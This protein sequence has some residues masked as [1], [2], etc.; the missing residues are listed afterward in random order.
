MTRTSGATVVAGEQRDLRRHGCPGSAGVDIF[1]VARQVDPQLE[2]VEEAALTAPATRAA[3]SMCSRPEPAVIHWVSPSVIVP[4][5]PWRVLVHE[6][7]VDDVGDGL[8]AAVR[9]PGGALGLARRVLD[10]THL[11][12]VDERVE[13][14]QVDP[15]EGAAHGEAL[16]LEA[17]RRGRHRAHRPRHGIRQRLGHARQG[18]D[19][20]D[21]HGWH[22]HQLLCTGSIL[23]GRRLL[24]PTVV[25]ASTIPT[26]PPTFANHPGA[27][28]SGPSRWVDRTRRMPGSATS[29]AR[30][31]PLMV[32]EPTT[33]VPS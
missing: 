28:G 12:H 24:R 22:G 6:D 1:I 3:T 7:A 11:V 21:G 2:A 31:V 18:Q 16:A 23:G 20:V 14:R 5:P 4:P 27:P 13:R 8:E 17:A 25:D 32:A 15:G 33:R 29:Q 26:I 30:P 9:V 10:L 19:V